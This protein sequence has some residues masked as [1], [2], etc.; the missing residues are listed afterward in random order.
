MD[1]ERIEA[2]WSLLNQPTMA[3][4]LALAAN[5][6]S[7]VQKV[8]TSSSLLSHPPSEEL[9]AER[10]SLRRLGE[11]IRGIELQARAGLGFQ[12]MSAYATLFEVAHSLLFFH[13]AKGRGRKW[14]DHTDREHAPWNPRA[15]VE[16][17]ERAMGWDKSRCDEEYEKYR[18]ACGFKHH[19]P[20]YIRL[21]KLPGDSDAFLG[22]FAV[23]NAAWL[24][25][26]VI[27]VYAFV[28]LS[29][30]EVADVV[31]HSSAIMES[32]EAMM[33]RLGIHATA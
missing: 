6:H 10:V 2:Q 17:T 11:D 30:K 16:G 14:L 31:P 3:P 9:F 25:A 28:R 7:L 4:V 29:A 23:C 5:A 24:S 18:F 27:G 8:A 26:A 33:P 1:W 15:L 21:K 13:Q 32:A 20:L 19:N 22:R 12:A